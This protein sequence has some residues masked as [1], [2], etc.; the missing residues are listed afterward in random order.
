MSDVKFGF[1]YTVREFDA[2]GDLVSET[3][4]RNLIPIEGLNH[5][6]DT[7][8]KNG[9]PFPALYC[10][11]GEA[12]Y[13]PVPA[14]EMATYPTVATECTAYTSATRPLITLGTVANGQVS[15]PT[16]VVFTGTTNGKVVRTGFVAVNSTKGGTSGP[17]LSAVKFSSPKALDAGGKLEVS[18]A[19]ASASI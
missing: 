17:L 14:D 19:F 16:P 4:D 1:V 6:I 2:S 8:L 11:L 5:F 15:T 9:T 10:G 7:T 13:T 18:V 12:D 3:V